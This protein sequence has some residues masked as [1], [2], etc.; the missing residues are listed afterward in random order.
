MVTAR[1]AEVRRQRQQAAAQ[2]RVLRRPV[3]G[4]RARRLQRSAR[5]LI[6]AVPLDGE[7]DVD[8]ARGSP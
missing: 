3:E 6:L 2:Q 5:L 1:R 7:L 4:G 8:V